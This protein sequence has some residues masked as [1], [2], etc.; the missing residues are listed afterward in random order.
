MSDEVAATSWTSTSSKVQGSTAGVQYGHSKTVNLLLVCPRRRLPPTPLQVTAL[1]PRNPKRYLLRS[2]READSRIV[3]Q[4]FYPLKGRGILGRVLA[5][6]YFSLAF[7]PTG[8]FDAS[9]SRLAAAP[10][11]SPPH[12]L[13]RHQYRPGGLVLKLD[14]EPRAQHLH[15]HLTFNPTRHGQT[16]TCLLEPHVFPSRIITGLDDCA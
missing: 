16:P 4:Q 14:S 5:C 6:L 11:P 3:Q 2:T 12:P 1:S 10:S 13:P 9:P 7:L 15:P 8:H